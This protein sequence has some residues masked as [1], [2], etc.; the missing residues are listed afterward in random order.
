MQLSAAQLETIRTRPQST[1]LYLSIFQPR[2]VMA[3]RVTGTLARGDR[4]IGYYNVTTGSISAIEAGMTLL[5]GTTPGG[6]ELGKVRIRSGTSSQFI[7]AENGHIDWSSA[8]YL[9]AQRYWEVWPVYPRII[10]DPSNSEDVIFYKDY[11]I[12][13]TNQNS[14]LGAFPCAGP[15][16]RGAFTGEQLYWSASGTSH[17]VGSN[18]TYDWA[19]EGGAVTGSTSHTPGYIT[20]NTPGNYVTR[21]KVSGANGSLDTTYRYVTV[22]DHPNSTGTNKPLQNWS[23]TNLSGSRA[24]GGYSASIRIT[25][26]TV[27]V[28]DG[29]V[30]VL[31]ADDWYGSSNQS[32]GGNSFN[33]SKIFFCGHVLDGSINYN[34]ADSS[35]EFQVGSISD[36]MKTSEG[37]SVTIESHSNPSKWFQLLDLDGRRAIYHYLKWH[38]TVLSVADFRFLGTDQ[39]IQYFDS[40]RASIFDAIDN[41][42]RGTLLG[43]VVADR[44]GILWAN[45][46]TAM[47][48]SPTGSF[49]TR[50]TMTRRDWANEP[51]IIDRKMNPLSFIEVGGIA[52]SGP[53]TGTFTAHLSNAPSSV[54]NT[55]GTI[56]R[57]QGLAVEGQTQTNRISGNLYAEKTHPYPTINMPLTGNYRN[58][59]IAPMEAVDV[60]IAASDTNSGIVLHQPYIID[61]MSWDY[62][63]ESKILISSLG[64]RVLT[65]GDAGETLTIPDVPD[66]GGFGGGGDFG[67]IGFSP[68]KFPPFMSDF[69]NKACG[70]WS[71]YGLATYEAGTFLAG[72]PIITGTYYSY[73]MPTTNGSSLL[74]GVAAVTVSG[75]Y[76]V[77]ANLHIHNP[78]TQDWGIA[79]LYKPDGINTREFIFDLGMDVDGVDLS[80]SYEALSFVGNSPGFFFRPFPSIGTDFTMFDFQ[81]S[82]SLVYQL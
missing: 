62:R 33:N 26:R 27:D 50:M 71:G 43:E 17:L 49:P 13:Y 31:W 37:F 73:G 14:I 65:G 1:E 55:R 45:V 11:D 70:S 30:V 59:D 42:M 23:L 34:Y 40:D 82:S 68:G 80:F 52:Y 75:V 53:T 22:R 12:P 21:L 64:L 47:Y 3:C 18:M 8:T 15:E 24:A 35:V 69:S 51:S 4:S 60:N 56:T 32:L 81:T 29:D 38:S 67:G 46:G 58:L 6:R 2:T 25:N 76:R 61:T 39:N 63:P 48:T 57:Q 66:T 20:Y 79:I 19:F 7:V 41:Y 5:V 28:N 54:P 16:I 36:V 9:T 74:G 10:P 78:N 77:S 72:T 44:Q